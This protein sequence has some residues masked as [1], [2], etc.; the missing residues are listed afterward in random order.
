MNA[1][2]AAHEGELRRATIVAN[3]K[4]RTIVEGETVQT[5]LD[6]IGWK[7]EWVVIEHNGEP[8]ARPAFALTPLRDGD[9]VEI[10][11]AV[12]GG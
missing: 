5:F 3:G 6:T 4:P 11:R 10:V 12:A 1:H 9:R 8:V 2:K 7:A